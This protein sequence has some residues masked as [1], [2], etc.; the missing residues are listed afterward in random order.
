M[1]I[2]ISILGTGRIAEFGYIPA[3][4]QIEDVNIIS[5]L[6][7]DQLRGEDFAR[8]NSIPN[9]YSNIDDLLEDKELDAIIICTPDAMHE[10]QAIKASQA[11]KHVLCEKPMATSVASCLR[12]ID[13]IKRSKII[14]GMAY[15]NRFNAGLRY[16]KDTID[17]NILGDIF[18]AR[19]ILST[20]QNDPEGWRAIGEQSNFWAMSATGSHMIDVFRWFFGEPT[21]V[22]ATTISPK[23]RSVNDELTS[24]ILNFGDHLICEITASAI[25]PK[26]NR[27]EIYSNTDS[28]IG[29][30]VFGIKTDELIY[31]NGQSVLIKPISSFFGEVIDFTNA[32]IKKTTP[33]STYIDGLENIRIMDVI[34]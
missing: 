19:A 24:L 9:S 28:I 8:K 12:M 25:T 29:E 34:R 20:Q 7:R 13:E 16:I 14:F 21:D 22:K 30:N 4:K 27:I 17:S 2:N 33:R 10:E 11:G 23:Y 6:S 5:V 31:H 3:I 1:A 18:Y 32:I 15:N 26:A